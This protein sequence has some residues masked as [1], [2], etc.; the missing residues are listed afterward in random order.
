MIN[1]RIQFILILPPPFL[2]FFSTGGDEAKIPDSSI[3]LKVTM[4]VVSDDEM[5]SCLKPAVST[6]SQAEHPLFGGIFLP[7]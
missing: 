6:M 1:I 2:A 7:V 3:D 5:R 4:I